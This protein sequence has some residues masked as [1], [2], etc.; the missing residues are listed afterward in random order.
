MSYCRGVSTG[1]GSGRRGGNGS[2]GDGQTDSRGGGRRGRSRG[3]GGSKG[4][5]GRLHLRLVTVPSAGLSHSRMFE[6]ERG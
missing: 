2:K 4:R 5:I 6:L 1:R 3:D